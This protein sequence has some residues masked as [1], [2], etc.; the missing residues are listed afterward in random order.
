MHVFVR[1]TVENLIEA[2]LAGNLNN[3]IMLSQG[4]HD[5]DQSG[6]L[7]QVS[8]A[9]ARLIFPPGHRKVGVP[10]TIRI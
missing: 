6:A 8:D 5:T 1:V 9:V 4:V 2:F 10:L 7:S 3:V